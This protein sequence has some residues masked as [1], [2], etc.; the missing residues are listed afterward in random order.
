[1]MRK[2]VVVK[3]IPFFVFFADPAFAQTQ[4]PPASPPAAS[5]ARRAQVDADTASALIV[6]KAPLQ[7]P[8]AARNA[9]IQGTV[10]L[11]V[12]TSYSGAVEEVTV[13]S[14]DP[15][16][17]QAAAEAVKQW[18]YKPYMVDGS[19][20]EM[21]TQVS[22]NFHLKASPAP[23][24]PPPP[25]PPLGEFRDDAYSND[26]F[27]I[28]YPLSRDWVRETDLLR[29]KA[30]SQGINSDTFVLLAALY[31]PRDASPY[32]ADSSFTLLALNRPVD[33]DCKQRLELFINDL[34]AHKDGKPKGGVSQFTSAGR[35]FYRAD[36]EFRQSAEHRAFVCLSSKDY[37]LQWN[38]V[39]STKQ[40]IETAVAT[41]A[42]ITSAPPTTTPAPQH[43]GNQ[44]FSTKTR[45]PPGLATGLLIKKVTPLYPPEAKYAHIQGTVALQAVI[46]KSGDVVDLEAISGPIE[47]VVSAVNAVRKWK[48]RPY[49]VNGEP[50]SVQTQIVVNYALQY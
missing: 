33:Q 15:V 7:Y 11:R 32:Q 21:E 8:A 26:F 49:L 22:I 20:T 2:L 48:Y 30:A 41:L 43:D 45:V 5:A 10:V 38:I 23:P 18:K 4:L 16:L 40:A 6:Q 14:G 17:A 1:M 50:V 25:A 44:D 9:G 39:G 27:G 34:Q 24:P 29:A 42:S 28:Y 19:P 46:S 3:L 35:D 37:F 36:F 47:L 13:V 12:V 31:I